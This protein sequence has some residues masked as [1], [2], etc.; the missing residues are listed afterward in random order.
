MNMAQASQR[1]TSNSK[2]GVGTRRWIGGAK[3][4][5]R[6]VCQSRLLW[7]YHVKKDKNKQAPANFPEKL[8]D[9]LLQLELF[10]DACELSLPDEAS[11]L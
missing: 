8:H 7:F 6:V 5:N 3:I 2:A 4:R 11:H 10:R 1:A 9:K